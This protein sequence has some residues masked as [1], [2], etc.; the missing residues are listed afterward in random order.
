MSRSRISK[1]SASTLAGAAAG[2]F[3]SGPGEMDVVYAK[4]A[5][6][7]GLQVVVAPKSGA[8]YL[9]RGPR[10]DPDTLGRAGAAWVK[11]AKSGRHLAVRR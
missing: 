7:A 3:N 4:E 10:F 6:Q 5:R 9:R 11:K 1:A 2:W 8:V